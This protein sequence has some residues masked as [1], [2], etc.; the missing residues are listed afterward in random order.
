MSKVDQL[1]EVIR[2]LQLSDS[3]RR[4]EFQAILETLAPDED[5]L[6]LARGEL[7][8]REGFLVATPRRVF[9]VHAGVA[10]RAIT[11][12]ASSLTAVR[13]HENADG[14]VNLVFR[15]DGGHDV[16]LEAVP[17]AHATEFA[18]RLS[19]GRENGPGPR[20]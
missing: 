4:A 19:A 9:F 6:A 16:E 3:V 18:R 12:I 5:V 14:T 11:P 10:G 13:Y 2:S 8:G 7:R 15:S 20:P 17:K 1:R